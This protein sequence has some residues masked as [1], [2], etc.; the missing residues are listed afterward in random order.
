MTDNALERRHLVA[1]AT[2]LLTAA[3]GGASARTINGSKPWKPHGG[4]GW[5]L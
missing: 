2:A 1:G 5:M 3:A 4:N